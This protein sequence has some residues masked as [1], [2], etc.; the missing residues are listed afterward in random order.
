MKRKNYKATFFFL[1]FWEKYFW[2]RRPSPRTRNRVVR[3]G[4]FAAETNTLKQDFFGGF[5][6]D[7]TKKK[8]HN[9]FHK[10]NNREFIRAYSVFNGPP[11]RR[12]VRWK[13]N[14]RS[15]TYNR[16]KN[17][18]SSPHTWR[19]STRR[20][21]A[22]KYNVFS[23]GP[24]SSGRVFPTCHRT[25]SVHRRRMTVADEGFRL[26]T[27]DLRKISLY[28]RVSDLSGFFFF[29]CLWGKFSPKFHL[30]FSFFPD[31]FPSTFISTRHGF[32]VAFSNSIGKK[33]VRESR[34][35]IYAPNVKTVK[36]SHTP[37]TK[38][39]ETLKNVLR[40]ERI[41]STIGHATVD[42]SP[43]TVIGKDVT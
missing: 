28:S 24:T 4:W 33:N 8:K 15:V 9:D 25:R 11:S 16:C 14:K 41:K 39:G 21:E 40:M 29:F 6:C 34:I 22:R 10:N 38:G 31:G 36:T 43:R 37:T 1:R 42:T 26:Q 17:R 13:S 27:N 32:S 7:K 12:N 20:R 30:P 35:K 2:T 18:L 5:D 23:G 3:Y 19:A